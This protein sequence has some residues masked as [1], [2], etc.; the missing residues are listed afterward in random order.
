MTRYQGIAAR[1]GAWGRNTRGGLAVTFAMA[2][3]VVFAALGLAS[4]YAMLTKVRS[5]LQTTADAAAIAG[6]REVPLAGDNEAQV[7]SAVKSFA[8]YSLTHDPNSTA[9]DLAAKNLTVDAMVIEDFS[10]VQVEISEAWT[11]FFAHFISD[12]ITPVTVTATA[13]FVGRNNICVLGMAQSNTG[14]LLD[15]NARLTGN[16]CGL[17]ANST[18]SNG[19]K[20]NSGVV[21]KA[22][23][24]CSSG[25]IGQGAATID[26]AP[27]TD[28]PPVEDPLKT[29]PAP[30]VGSCD[31]NDLALTSITKTLDPGVYCGGLLIDGTSNISL[32]PGIYVIKD[33]AL[34]VAGSA[35]LSGDGVGFFITGAAGATGFASNTHISLSAP[36]SGPMAGLLI[37]EDRTLASVLKHK[38]TSDDARRLI[39]TIYLP[40]GTLIVDAK[41]PVADQSA[42]TAILVNKLELNGGPNLVLNSDYETTDVPVPSGIAGSRQV[43]LSN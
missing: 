24:I 32:N 22:A 41:N 11:P 42:Y 12:G 3:P 25:G 8:A 18:A 4:D 7:I 37:F 30:T 43:V 10:A 20:V 15:K 9:D 5:D 35:T 34:K 13:R 2:L 33:G 31:H 29:R 36:E 14:V 17:F 21:L 23:I 1:I 16:N 6:A 19:L 27:L 28:C 40:V 38:I 26:P 39:G